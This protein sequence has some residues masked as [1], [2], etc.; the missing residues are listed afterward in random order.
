MESAVT[1][2]HKTSQDI[3]RHHKTK[4]F[5]SSWNTS[6]TWWLPWKP[7]QR[8]MEPEAGQSLGG[9]MGGSTR[10]PWDFV[11]RFARC[12]I[13]MM[14]STWWFI[15]RIVSGLVHPSYK[16]TLPPLIPF[17]TR[18][19]QGY[20]PL[21]KWGEP[22]STEFGHLKRRACHKCMVKW[23]HCF[24]LVCFCCC[25]SIHSCLRIASSPL[26]GN[27]S[28]DENQVLS[29]SCSDNT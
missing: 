2:H 14:S 10:K 7:M 21:T 4:A 15:P 19:Y 3:T 17:I 25:P 23:A 9:A 18:V 29:H 28:H 26:E 13:P 24:V 6:R 5:T 27:F 16:W 1:R 11:R 22:P 12:W 8:L 20:N